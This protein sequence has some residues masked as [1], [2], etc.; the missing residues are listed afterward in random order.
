MLCAIIVTYRPEL[1]RLEALLSACL[2]QADKLVVVDNGSDEG[3]LTMLRTRARRDGFAV[4]ELG[5]NLGVAAA[6]NRGVA[7]AR[8]Q[9]CEHVLFLDQDSVPAPDMVQKLLAALAALQAEGVPVAAVGPKLVDNRT[10]AGTPFVNIGLLGVRRTHCSEPGENRLLTD[11]LISSGMLLPLAMLDRVGLPEEALFIDNVDLEWSFRARAQ[12]LLLYGVC[13]AVMKHSVGDQVVTLGKGV[14]HRHGPLRQYYIM[15]NRILLYRR[16][17]AP[18]GW[19]AQ[20]CFRMLFK[21]VAF[22]L[23]FAPRR[24]NFRMMLRGARDALAGRMGRYEG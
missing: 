14:I 11:F 2:P 3:A 21:F 22:S 6:Q 1:A 20:D 17:Y 4:L 13:G 18:A 5:D 9:T 12:G 15:R 24:E 10:G 19:V 7:W 23:F 8:T 16:G